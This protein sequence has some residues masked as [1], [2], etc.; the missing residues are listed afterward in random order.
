MGRGIFGSQVSSVQTETVN[1]FYVDF[2]LQ[3][4]GKG[5]NV[6]HGSVIA[7]QSEHI[8][9]AVVAKVGLSAFA[10]LLVATDEHQ[11]IVGMELNQQFGSRQTDATAK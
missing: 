3:S 1:P 9:L 5:V 8:V 2:V 10:T 11:S 7:S 4:L 6:L